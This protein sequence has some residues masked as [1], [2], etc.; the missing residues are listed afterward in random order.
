MSV[1][2][3]VW[4]DAL[5][6]ELSI[7]EYEEENVILRIDNKSAI[8]L[9]KHPITHGKNK[10]IEERFHFL[11]EQVTSFGALKEERFKLEMQR[12]SH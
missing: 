1:C 5:M 2:Q 10:H 9:A 3:V 11:R 7:K 12:Q 8:N 4:L 6:T